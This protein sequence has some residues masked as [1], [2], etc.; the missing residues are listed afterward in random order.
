VGFRSRMTVFFLLIVIVPMVSVAVIVFRLISDNETG[1]AD[2]RLE[3]GQASARGLYREFLDRGAVAARRIAAD[4]E[5]RAALRDG[6]RDAARGRASE[7][8]EP[9]RL[10]RI[11]IV[12]D[13]R[14]IVDVG[15]RSAIA[16]ARLD[17]TGGGGR[18]IGRVQVSA[19]DA[20]E[21]ADLAR[22]TTE[23][24]VLVRRG[25][26]TLAA[27][28]PRMSGDDLPNVGTVEEQG[29]EFRVATFEAPDFGDDPLR[30]SVLSDAGRVSSNVDEGRLLAGLVLVGFLILAFAF[31]LAVSRSL[32]AQIGRFLEAARRLGGGDFSTEVPIE[33]R[34]E[35]SALGEEFN[36]MSRQLEVRLEELR[37]ERQR[38][39]TAMRRIGDTFASNLDREGLLEI[40]VRTA[41][42][43]VIAAGG[44]ASVRSDP[45]AP[46]EPRTGVGDVE[47]YE[48]VL[49]AAEHAALDSIAPA[50]VAVD[51]KSALAFPLRPAER[52][53]RVLGLVSVARD[54]RPFSEAER[55]LFNYLAGQ[56]AVSIENVDLHELV[57]RQAV[58]DE[59]TG[60]FNHRRFQE[61]VAAEVERA[62]RFGQD[63]GM[64]MLDIDNFKQINDTYGHQQGDLV[65]REV[66][67]VLRESSREIDEPARYGGEEMAV[68]LPQTDLDG[69]YN[70]A[71]RVRASIEALEIRRLR[72]SGSLRVT[73]SLGVAALPESAQDKDALIAAAD[74]ALYQAKRA[75]KNRTERA[76]PAGTRPVV[77]E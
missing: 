6:S 49:S 8:I 42:D 28:G 34:D 25:R 13:G 12:S 62:K 76:A 41:V 38:L 32:Q 21:Y 71:E 45:D 31:A 16:P 20:P 61:V 77:A 67:R 75:G 56:A 29:E 2:A 39:Q 15:R 58:T 4:P 72:G 10:E 68:A 48:N 65:L 60:L 64:L 9:G 59:L 5:L 37:L 19:I 50:E 40:V 66:A 46:L 23:F 33:G 55:E 27:T 52:P 53:D 1:K 54:G 51:G 63:L 43:G 69:A 7:L 73:A 74:A 18:R 44:R 57:Q 30:V 11:T 3:Q 47:G 26:R 14:T 35:F 24:E 22:R 36:K 70:L 17:L